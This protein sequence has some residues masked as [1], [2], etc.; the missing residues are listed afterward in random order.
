MCSGLGCDTLT[1]ARDVEVNINATLF[2]QTIAFAFFV[3]FCMRFLWPPL[4]QALNDRQKKI[5]DGLIAAEKAE[6]NLVLSRDKAGANLRDARAQAQDLIDGANKQAAEIIDEAKRLAREEGDRLKEAANLEI[7][8]EVVRAKHNLRK[9][10]AALAIV[11]VERIL[12]ERV[13]AS[14]NGKL[15]DDLAAQL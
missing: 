4:I 1:K 15:I 11:G 5:A 3:W 6:H 12:G 7:K 2:G 14:I 13:D 10:V 8:Q 9:Q